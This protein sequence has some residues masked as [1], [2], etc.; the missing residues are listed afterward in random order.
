MPCVLKQNTCNLNTGTGYLLSLVKVNHLMPDEWAKTESG[1][2]YSL[3]NHT[4]TAVLFSYL[5]IFLLDPGRLCLTLKKYTIISINWTTFSSLILIFLC[6]FHK[7]SKNCISTR[8]TSLINSALLLTSNGNIIMN[9]ALCSHC[10][11]H[12]NCYLINFLCSYP[13]IYTKGKNK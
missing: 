7:L 13:I 3:L 12:K 2:E 6:S 11:Y 9:T 1:T 10:V 4:T 5:F 8:R